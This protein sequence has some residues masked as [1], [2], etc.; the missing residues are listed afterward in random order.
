VKVVLVL[1]AVCSLQKIGRLFWVKGLE[2]RG[3][4][5][6]NTMLAANI[7]ILLCFFPFYGTKSGESM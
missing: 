1:T 6:L 7:P 4:P 5:V 2:K 3:G